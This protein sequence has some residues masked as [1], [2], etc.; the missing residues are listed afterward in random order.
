VNGTNLGYTLEILN[1]V[2]VNNVAALAG[3]GIALQ[4]AVN[5]T[6][7]NNTVA[8][9]D[10]TA[11]AA[12]AFVAGNLTESVPQPAGIVTS[13]HS[14]AFTTLSGQPFSNPVLRNNIVVSNRSFFRDATLDG[15]LGGLRPASQ[16]SSGT[17]TADFWDL[18]VT[19][20]AGAL[21]P[22][23]CL[24]SSLTGMLGE[25][26]AD[27]TNLAAAANAT[28]FA[29]GYFNELLSAAAGDEGGNFVNISF[30]PLSLSAGNYHLVLGAPA[31]D[32]GAANNTVAFPALAADFDG[33]VRPNPDTGV[34]DIGADEFYH[35][36]MVGTFLQGQWFLDNGNGQW[37][38]G[39]DTVIDNFGI[40]GDIAVTG[41]MN[42]DGLSEI[43]VW[44]PATGEWFFDLDRN[45]S[46]SGCG[47]DLCL[48]QFGDPSHLPV[49]GDWDG[50]GIFQV[51]T[52]HQGQWFLDNGNGQWDPGTDTEIAN[53]GAPGDLPVTGD[54]N[55]DGLSEV[56]V[57]RPSTGEWFFDLDN[58][59][60]W[61]G[62]G[63]D[64]CLTQFGDPSHLPVTGDWNGDGVTE[65]GTF[66]QG[67]WF[68]DNGNG[69]WDGAGVDTIYGNF[70]APGHQPVTGFWQ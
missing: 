66:R 51:G 56:G 27:G 8:H 34:V 53:F 26:Y 14:E 64:L 22:D 37:D 3:G 19:G 61:S 13:A 55:G 42:N 7:I 23:N 20:I 58:S 11:T 59:G 31:I 44:R 50:D 45:G 46:W 10:S 21:N 63:P 36:T 69:Q 2:I 5:T 17:F 32:A 12:E 4:Q 24:L 6:I 40:P 28:G 38:P 48:P 65:V 47:P 15:G 18:G 30:T 52:Y 57:W 67:Q 9:N 70:G 1:N 60:S 16:H 41:D 68:L 39:L 49:T 43:G 62:C 54:M 35:I 29:G 25:N 33:Q